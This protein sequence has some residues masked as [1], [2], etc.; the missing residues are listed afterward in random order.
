VC[1]QRNFLRGGGRDG[2][3]I[4]WVSCNRICQPKEKGGLGIKYLEI[5]NSSLLC[6]WK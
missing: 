4:C 2:K 1:L 3:K 5:F 6:K